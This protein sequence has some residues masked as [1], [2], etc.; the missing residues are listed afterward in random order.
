MRKTKKIPA[1]P[2]P[3][4]VLDLLGQPLD[5]DAIR[6]RRV[7]TIADLVGT[8]RT[9]IDDEQRYLLAFRRLPP[10]EQVEFRDLMLSTLRRRAH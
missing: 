7:L 10:A 3:G 4:T 5:K 9:E 1:T 6:D 2:R 8:T